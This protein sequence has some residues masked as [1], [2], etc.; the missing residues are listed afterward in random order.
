FHKSGEFGD[1]RTLDTMADD[2]VAG[3]RALDSLF[4]PVGWQK[5]FVP[6][7][8]KLSLAFKAL[9]PKLGYLGLSA[10]AGRTDL[11]Q[12]TLSSFFRYNTYQVRKIIVMED[13]RIEHDLADHFAAKNIEWRSTTRRIGQIKAIDI[14]YQVVETDFIFHC[15][16]D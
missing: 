16:D 9:I 3:A 2:A 13:G 6:P 7:N 10:G 4:G 8:H 1:G 15:E 14:A 5:V 11:L 12:H